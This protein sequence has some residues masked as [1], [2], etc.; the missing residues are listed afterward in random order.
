MR[1][2]FAILLVFFGVFL[3][4]G[5]GVFE[6]PRPTPTFPPT[7]TPVMLLPTF[8]PVPPTE[9]PPT[10]TTLPQPTPTGA[11]FEPVKATITVDNFKLRTGP[12]FLFDAVALYDSNTEVLVMGKAPGENW[13]FVQTEDNRSGWMKTEY[14][15]LNGDL[16]ALPLIAPSD[17]QTISGHVRTKDNNTFAS[18]IGILLEPQSGYTGTN[19]DNALTDSSGTFYI[20]LPKRM[21]GDYFIEPNGFNCTG[22][23]VVGKCEL[24]YDLPIAQP[25]TLPMKS[26]VTIEFVLTPR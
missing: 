21:E 1:K 16:A 14:L 7:S 13:L 5:C 8:T 15:D 9:V 24:P 22:N 25:L 17:V 18:G 19:G 23:L 11:P 4:A 12:G 2:Y 10:A 3:L 20:Y 6:Q 26:D